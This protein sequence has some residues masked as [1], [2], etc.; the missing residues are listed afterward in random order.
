MLH[1]IVKLLKKSTLFLKNPRNCSDR[2]L[3]QNVVHVERTVFNF[4][5]YEFDV[6]KALTVQMNKIQFTI[7]VYNSY[8]IVLPN[9]RQN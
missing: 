9:M 4:L 8:F 2:P 5:I 7:S 3:V 6:H 1:S